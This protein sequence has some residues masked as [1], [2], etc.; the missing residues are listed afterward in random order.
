MTEDIDWFEVKGWEK[1]KSIGIC[2]REYSETG[3]PKKDTRYFIT[4]LGIVDI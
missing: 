3:I 4:S 2:N 1:L